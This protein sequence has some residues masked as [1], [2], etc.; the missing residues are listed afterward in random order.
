[1]STL[2]SSIPIWA[3]LLAG[4]LLSFYLI[5]VIVFVALEIRSL[6]RSWNSYD[7]SDSDDSL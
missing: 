2:I 4:F 5:F 3:H 7:S 1:M 6:K